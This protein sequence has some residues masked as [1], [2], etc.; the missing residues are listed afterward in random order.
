MMLKNTL[1]IL[2]L[3]ILLAAAASGTR[4]QPASQAVRAL[5]IEYLAHLATIQITVNGTGPHTFIVDTGA[6][7]TVLNQTLAASLNLPVVGKTEVGSPMGSAPIEADSLAIDS[8]GIGAVMISNPPAI[9]MELDAIFSPLD[10]PAG[11]L[12][13]ASLDGYLMTIDFPNGYVLV[14]PGELPPADGRRVLEYGHGSVVPHLP[15]DVAGKTIDV[16]LDTGAPTE[17]SLPSHYAEVLPLTSPPAVTGTGR[18]V[19]AEFEVS[20]ATLDGSLNLGE[21]EFPGATIQFNDRARYGN[22]GMR[23]LA[24]LSLTIDSK[25]HRIAVDRPGSQGESGEPVKRVLKT[26]G[27]R[28]G[29]GIR[30]AGLGGDVLNVLGVDEGM[31]AAEG[32][33]MKGDSITA[34]NGRPVIEL[35]AE[36][37]MACLRG[38][39][40]VLIVRRGENEL[41]LTLSL[42]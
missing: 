2:G 30:L 26:G 19:D 24:E 6:G 11:I 18:T 22:L 40:V 5:P 21:I 35:S 13:A 15:I 31:A 7:V 23:I 14:R 4:A 8:L 27:T 17:I 20:T 1:Q 36:E 34:M 3:G 12:A 42:D 28:R 16:A 29:Y 39:P 9:A 37:R 32:G 33:L 38:S 41:S 25:N 10:A